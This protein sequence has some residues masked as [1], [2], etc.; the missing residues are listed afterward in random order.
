MQINSLFVGTQLDIILLFFVKGHLFINTLVHFTYF[1]W[2][3]YVQIFIRI[4][5]LIDM[6][7]HQEPQKC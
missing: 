7:E 5:M 1:I 3:F 4:Y 6:V 2:H